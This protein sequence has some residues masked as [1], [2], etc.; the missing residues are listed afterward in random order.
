MIP[1]QGEMHDP[2]MLDGNA[3]AGLLQEVFGAEMTPAPAQCGHCGQVSSVGALLVFGDGM[4]AVLRCPSCKNM[5]MRISQRPGDAL[6]EMQ[7]V[8]YLRMQREG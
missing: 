8:R 4:G 2:L 6:L 1:E 7:G 5:M 3:V